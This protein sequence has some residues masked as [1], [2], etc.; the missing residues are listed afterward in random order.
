MNMNR[1]LTIRTFSRFLFFLLIV[2]ACTNTSNLYTW[3]EVDR[4]IVKEF[5]NIPQLTTS[6]LETLLSNHKNEVILLDARESN[7]FAISHLKGAHLVESEIEALTI[8][9]DSP[10]N[11]VIVAYCSVGYR[12]AEL[13]EGLQD[14]GFSNTINLQGS[15]F[16]W[17][18]EGRPVYKGNEIVK[19]VHPY[20]QKWGTLL[21]K[22]LWSF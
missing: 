13:V 12:S 6:E 22:E 10:A 16:K 2:N 7:E 5:P 4:L 17:A 3:A 21:N 15:L 20:N 11:A 19:S 18:N 14:R 9:D 8:I 1:T